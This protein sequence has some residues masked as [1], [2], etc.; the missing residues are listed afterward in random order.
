MVA[1]VVVREVMIIIICS[2]LLILYKE[3]S[4]VWH[5]FLIQV[6]GMVLLAEE[7]PEVKDKILDR[8]RARELAKWN[9]PEPTIAEIRKG[10]EPGLSDDDLL[11]RWLVTKDEFTAM[12]DA[13]PTT[14]Y[15][16][17]DRPLLSLLRD[18]R[19]RKANHVYIRKP[20]LKLSL[21]GPMN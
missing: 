3:A 21:Q 16:G 11:L 7:A 12:R 2:K 4:Q 14:T 6:D 10:F 20:G 18:L 8:P 19:G 1:V 17:N 13:G 15:A 5:P 9:P